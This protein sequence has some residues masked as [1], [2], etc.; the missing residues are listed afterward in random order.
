V[1]RLITYR[2]TNPPTNN[3]RINVSSGNPNDRLGGGGGGGTGG[4]GYGR[5]GGNP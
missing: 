1:P 5:Y 3:P 4:P 2:N